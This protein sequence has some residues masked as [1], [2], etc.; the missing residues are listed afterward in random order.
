MTDRRKTELDTLAIALVIGCCAIWGLGQVAAK[1][2]LTSLPPLMQASLRSLIAAA[3]LLVW[4]R[5]RGQRVFQSDGT[6]RAG[7]LAGSL[8]AIEFGCIFLGLQFT[9]ASR[10]AV[11]IYLA[12]FV[13]AAGM[14]LISPSERLA[15][16][17]LLGLAAAFAGVVWAFSEGFAQPSAGPRQWLGDALG[18]AGGALWGLT[19]LTLRASRLATALPEKTLL[20]QLGVSGL[21]LGLASWALH[22][23]WPAQLGAPAAAALA[24]QSVVVTFASYL[25]WFWLIRHYP[26]TRISAFTLLTPVFGLLAGVALLGDPLT[27]RLLAALAAVCAGIALVSHPPPRG[28]P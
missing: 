15:P 14:P 2:G 26:A 25:V 8:F 19:T 21:A 1:I 23:T 7:L 18:I 12:P 4:S 11:F 9:T 22:E 16:L 10:M 28:A 20:Y 17:Q 5:L 3:M 13:V 24:F 27:P 6:G